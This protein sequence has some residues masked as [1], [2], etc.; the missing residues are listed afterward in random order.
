MVNYE[1]SYL[2]FSR[3]NLNETIIQFFRGLPQSHVSVWLTQR[4]TADLFKQTRQ[5]ISPHLNNYYREK[6]L[7]N[8]A[9]VKDSL[10]I[11]HSTTEFISAVR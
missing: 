11:H 10:T 9:T 3:L 5:N 1:Y 6:E 4:Q 7:S 8:M 2:T